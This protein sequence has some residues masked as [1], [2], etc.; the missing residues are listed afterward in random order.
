MERIFQKIFIEFND[1]KISVQRSFP[2]SDHLTI[3]SKFVSLLKFVVSKCVEFHLLSLRLN[4]SC[5]IQLSV[6]YNYL[7]YTII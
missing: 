6:L 5:S 3:P 1:D 2:G 7:F 4:I